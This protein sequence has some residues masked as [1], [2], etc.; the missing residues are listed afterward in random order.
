[1]SIGGSQHCSDRHLAH[2]LSRSGSAR[3][4]AI[5]FLAVFSASVICEAI[6]GRRL[7]HN[8]NPTGLVNDLCRLCNDSSRAWTE[9][10][11]MLMRR[12]D[13]AI[14]AAKHVGRNHARS[15]DFRAPLE[16]ILGA[17]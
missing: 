3:G 6:R 4:L 1:M 10:S 11:V 16:T 9:H 8:T 17:N 12:A 13:E 15:A 14:Y 5:C 7:P 2:A